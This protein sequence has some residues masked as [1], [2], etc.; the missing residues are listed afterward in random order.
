MMARTT[1]DRVTIDPRLVPDGEWQTACSIL[2][3]SIRLA[4]A[5]PAKREDYERWKAERR[6]RD[7]QKTQTR[8]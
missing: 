4:L 8:T 7:G 2:A 5:D 3:A 6:A 1:T